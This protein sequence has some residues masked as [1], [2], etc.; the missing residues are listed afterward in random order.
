MAVRRTTP[1]AAIQSYMEEQVKELEELIA[2]NLMYVGERCVV[3]ARTN[4]SYT[5]Q[6]GNLR[7]S[8]GYV[9]LKD[10]VAV[11]QGGFEPMM[12]GGTGSRQ[13]KVFIE[14]LTRSHS[15]GIVLIVVAGMNYAAYVEA[16][17]YIVIDSAQLLAERLVPQIMKQLGF[18]VR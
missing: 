18:E 7:S 16:L 10:G 12:K 17:N 9:V 8:I 4:G 2:T 1:L 14:E 5:D 6:T 3:E 11:N 15:K 13:G